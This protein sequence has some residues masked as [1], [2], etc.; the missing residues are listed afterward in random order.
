M[1]YY[2]TLGKPEDAGGTPFRFTALIDSQYF[3]QVSGNKRPG[4][5][6]LIHNLCGGFAQEEIRTVLAE[7]EIVNLQ[8]LREVFG[9]FAQYLERT[10]EGFRSY[11]Y[12]IRPGAETTG[13]WEFSSQA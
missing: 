3:V 12:W 9:T 5:A 6:V 10:A 8:Q 7:E 4:G 2:L 1:I 11:M 13:Q